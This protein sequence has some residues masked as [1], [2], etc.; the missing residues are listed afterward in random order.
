MI[1][2]VQ[3]VYLKINNSMFEVDVFISFTPGLFKKKEKSFNFQAMAPSKMSAPMVEKY[4][5]CEVI[6]RDEKLL[7]R[8][9]SQVR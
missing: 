1:M 6:F 5:Q 7:I 2:K 3:F 8:P 9:Y 4:A